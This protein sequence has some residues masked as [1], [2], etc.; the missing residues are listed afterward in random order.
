MAY[1][2]KIVIPNAL[3]KSLVFGSNSNYSI[4]GFDRLDDADMLKL[5]NSGSSSEL[6]FYGGTAAIRPVSQAETSDWSNCLILVI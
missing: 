2:F 3:S 4:L 6:D 1:E 5:V